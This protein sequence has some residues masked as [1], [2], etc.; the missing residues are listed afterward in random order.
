MATTLAMCLFRL[1]ADSPR[2][3]WLP[4]CRVGG[5]MSR[6]W[7]NSPNSLPRALI[8]TPTSSSLLRGCTTSDTRLISRTRGSTRSMALGGRPVGAR[9]PVHDPGPLHGSGSAQFARC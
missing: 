6:L 9:A 5:F 3:I 2:V 1:P 4:A 8:L 7:R